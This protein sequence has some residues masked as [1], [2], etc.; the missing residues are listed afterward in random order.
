MNMDDADCSI[1][2]TPEFINTPMD[3]DPMPMRPESPKRPRSRN[4]HESLVK[5]N[6]KEWDA[7]GNM[8][9]SNLRAWSAESM[10]FARRYKAALSA[11]NAQFESESINLLS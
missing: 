10:T 2:E 6:E 4:A 11:V 5:C 9:A 1:I 8:I 7:F 3:G